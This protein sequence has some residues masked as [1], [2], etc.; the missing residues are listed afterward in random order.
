MNH[1][2]KHRIKNNQ[3]KTVFL[4][5][6]LYLLTGVSFTGATTNTIYQEKND[7][8]KYSTPN[9]T[10]LLDSTKK[11]VTDILYLLK[12]DKNDIAHLIIQM[13]TMVRLGVIRPFKNISLLERTTKEDYRNAWGKLKLSHEEIKENEKLIAQQIG[14]EMKTSLVIDEH[15][16]LSL[17]NNLITHNHIPYAG[18]AISFYIKSDFSKSGKREHLYTLSTV[19]IYTNVIE[20]NSLLKKW[21]DKFKHN[22]FDLELYGYIHPTTDEKIIYTKKKSL[23]PLKKHLNMTKGIEDLIIIPNL[24]K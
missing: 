24:T 19:E 23:L 13:D 8:I 6:T 18:V 11:H 9:S 21:E 15:Q 2:N 17:C 10:I 12:D 3:T 5:L 14:V 4:L 22:D 20:Y 16:V 1:K 7:T